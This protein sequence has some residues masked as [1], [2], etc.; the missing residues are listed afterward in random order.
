MTSTG[1]FKHSASIRLSD[2]PAPRRKLRTAAGPFCAVIELPL[3]IAVPGSARRPAHPRSVPRQEQ[4][5]VLVHIGGKPGPPSGTSLEDKR[6]GTVGGPRPRL[7]L[8]GT[9]D[10]HLD[11]AHRPLPMRR[12]HT[13]DPPAQPAPK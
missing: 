5:V 9:E 1:S 10:V 12:G 8:A 6:L 3:S 4:F 13:L 7:G 2:V 11:G